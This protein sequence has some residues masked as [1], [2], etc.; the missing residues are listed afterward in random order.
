MKH[1]FLYHKLNNSFHS[2]RLQLERY[3]Q[4]GTVMFNVLPS[5]ADAGWCVRDLFFFSAAC[6]HSDSFRRTATGA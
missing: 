5:S 3:G 1:L 2:G 6:C 4:P